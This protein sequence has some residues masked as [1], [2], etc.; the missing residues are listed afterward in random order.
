M[1]RLTFAATANSKSVLRN[2]QA[3]ATFG[4]ATID[5]SAAVLGGHASAKAVRTLAA[6]GAGVAKSFLHGEFL[7]ILGRRVAAQGARA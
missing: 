4:T 3:N 1:R 2:R 6:G 5:H 7:I